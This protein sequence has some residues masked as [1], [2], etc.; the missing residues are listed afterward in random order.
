[1]SR[2]IIVYST[3]LCVPCE[4]LKAYLRREGIDFTVKDLLMDEAAAEKLEALNIRTTP[5]LEI[6]GE[7]LAGNA[8]TPEAIQER[9]AS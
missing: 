6:D 7:V 8:L 5:A 1:M 9:L 2:S 3:P 4:G